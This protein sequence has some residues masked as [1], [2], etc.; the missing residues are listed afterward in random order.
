MTAKKRLGKKKMRRRAPLAP[1]DKD[2]PAA[3]SDCEMEQASVAEVDG[4]ADG[5]SAPLLS[6]R[7]SFEVRLLSLARSQGARQRFPILSPTWGAW[8]QG[9]RSAPGRRLVSSL[10]LLDVTVFISRLRVLCPPLKPQR[11]YDRATRTAARP[12]GRL[13]RSARAR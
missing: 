5:A 10:P 11:R 4:A 13:P 9:A 8:F 6:A 2:V 1:V 12:H 3:S 7:L